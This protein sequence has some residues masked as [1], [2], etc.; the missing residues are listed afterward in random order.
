[1]IPQPESSR[2]YETTHSV[3][4]SELFLRFRDDDHAWLFA[5]WMQE[6]WHAFEAWVEEKWP[7]YA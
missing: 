2:Q 7:E 1:M 6:Y 5:D 4:E 3:A